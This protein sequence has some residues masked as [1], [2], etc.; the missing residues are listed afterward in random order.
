MAH[1]QDEIP[2]VPPEW[3]GYEIATSRL[4]T[5]VRHVA[6]PEK[7]TVILLH[8]LAVHGGMY[9]GGM[10]RALSEHFDVVVP[11]LRGHGLTEAPAGRWEI[12]DFAD[13]VAAL[14]DAMTVERAHVLGY[15]MGGFIA[16]SFA[17]R[18]PDRLDRLVLMCTAP[19]QQKTSTRAGLAA[20]QVL[21]RVVPPSA[22]IPIS[23]YLLSGP[24]MPPQMRY[25]LPWLLQ[26]NTRR[27]ISGS[28]RALR[29]ADLRPGLAAIEHRTLVVTAE[30]DV[31]IPKTAWAPLIK[32]LQNVRHEHFHDGGH[33]IAASHGAV[34]GALVTEFL[35][36]AAGA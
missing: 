9:E 4:R 6:A 13:D 36:E 1:T 34:L 16:Q 32:E 26:H 2:D 21:F 7:P 10:R 25:I 23:R 15:S 29:R 30:H 11:D 35:T 18:H 19:R 20:L 24:G 33:G 14:L 17:Q 5:W 31:A 12:E 3:P 8:G 22:M 28:T 27:G